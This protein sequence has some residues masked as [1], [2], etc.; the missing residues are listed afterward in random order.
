MM[1]QGSG[2]GDTLAH[3]FG[4]LGD[5]LPAVFLQLEQPEQGPRPLA[6][7][8]PRQ[9]IHAPNK[10]EKLAT[11]QA[12]KEQRLIGHQSNTLFDLQRLA[13]HRHAEQLDRAGR[14]RN[15]SGEHPDGGRLARAVRTEKAEEAAALHGEAQSIHGW[16]VSVDFAQVSYFDRRR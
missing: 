7:Y 13:G 14:R 12:V 6:R 9:P 16:F 1:D 2:H 15:Q 10:F 3:S 5:Q 4:I 8:G 11:G